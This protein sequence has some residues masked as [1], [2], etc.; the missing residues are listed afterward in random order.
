[1]SEALTE[2]MQE[3]GIKVRYLHSDID[4]LDRIEIIQGLR[5]GLFDVLIGVNLLREGLDLPGGFAV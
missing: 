5:E 3:S 4:T 1:M 2:F